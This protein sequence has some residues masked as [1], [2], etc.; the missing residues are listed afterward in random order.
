METQVGLIMPRGNDSLVQSIVP[1]H[2][3]LDVEV[4]QR[5]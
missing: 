2:P 5:I 1:H 4:S 3:F